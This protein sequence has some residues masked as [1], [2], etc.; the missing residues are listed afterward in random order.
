MRHALVIAALAL[1]GCMSSPVRDSCQVRCGAGAACPE[2]YTCGGDDFCH[3]SSADAPRDCAA[4]GDGDAGGD[5]PVAACAPTAIEAGSH[6]TCALRSDG[7]LLCWGEGCHGELG[8]AR[9][10]DPEACDGDA[11]I[12]RSP[13]EVEDDGAPLEEVSAV[14]LGL[15]HTCALVGDVAHCFGDDRDGQLGR[16]TEGA[17]SDDPAPIETDGPATGPLVQLSAGWFH[18]CAAEADGDAW[19]WGNNSS[20]QVGADDWDGALDDRPLAGPVDTAD[21]L[22]ALAAGGTHTCAVT[23]GGGARCW[24]RNQTGQLGSSPEQDP[25]EQPTPVVVLR[26]TDEEPL[27]GVTAIAADSNISCAATAD[28][29][30]VYCWGENDSH[31]L[32]DDSAPEQ[33]DGLPAW[34]ARRAAFTPDAAVIELS[35]GS[36]N[37]CA[38]LEGGDLWC[39]G[40][41]DKG[42]MGTGG[43]EPWLPP[44]LVLADVVDVAVGFEHMCAVVDGGAVL[45]WGYNLDG[46]LGTGDTLSIDEPT[47]IQGVCP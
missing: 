5:G 46:Q 37:A 20:G 4:A 35:A 21:S 47:E 19:C 45:C 29:D 1:N 14:S 2:D 42:Q 9:Q 43:D 10:A 11:A 40:S 36:K 28:P 12:A 15:L 17:E 30:E 38:L 31:S 34:L 22:V 25:T 18:G 39:W 6:H 24:G 27:A 26:E 32:G 44:T 8:A 7:H 13:I 16:G 23:A 41:N 3:P 33:P